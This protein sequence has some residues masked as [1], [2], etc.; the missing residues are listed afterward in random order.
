MIGASPSSDVVDLTRASVD[1]M[2]TDMPDTKIIDSTA[3]AHKNAI[4]IESLKYQSIELKNTLN[5]T[6]S[7]LAI[8]KTEKE[9]EILVLNRKLTD[10]EQRFDEQ[11]DIVK[12]DLE[13]LRAEKEKEIVNLNQII[14]NQEN[15]INTIISSLEKY[16]TFPIIRLGRLGL[17]FWRKLYKG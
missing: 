17:R 10:Q 16:Q 2:Q 7:D 12:R 6:K 11:F 14:N 3:T 8:L 5:V 15:F 13:I 1:I 9:K 4:W